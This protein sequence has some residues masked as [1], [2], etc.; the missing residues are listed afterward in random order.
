M[1]GQ[2]A[3]ASA[4]GGLAGITI[5]E[6]TPG[7][8]P[9]G[10]PPASAEPEPEHTE[11][12][13]AAAADAPQLRVS[14]LLVQLERER[15]RH[16]DAEAARRAVEEERAAMSSRLE[17]VEA[18]AQALRAKVA[19]AQEG[20]T[21]ARLREERDALLQLLRVALELLS[22]TPA[23]CMV[24]CTGATQAWLESGDDG[25]CMVRVT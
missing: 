13:D 18:E 7:G 12:V 9:E 21:I 5:P 16:Q 1:E 17:A 11:A 23:A 22:T 20:E 8:V 2:L 6:G 4:D 19:P 24:R 14:N 25:T 3:A 10:T 15:Q